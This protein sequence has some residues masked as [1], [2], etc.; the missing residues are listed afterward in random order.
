MVSKDEKEAINKLID[1]NMHKFGT[2][3][4]MFAESLAKTAAPM[5]HLITKTKEIDEKLARFVARNIILVTTLHYCKNID[6]GMTLLKECEK[7]IEKADKSF[8]EN[9]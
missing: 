7:L 6:D 5:L 8:T 4:R 1:E 9:M 3:D 2:Q